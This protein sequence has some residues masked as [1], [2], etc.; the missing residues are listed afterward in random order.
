MV[1]WAGCVVGCG[2]LACARGVC[3][4]SAAA[5]LSLCFWLDL[6]LREGKNKRNTKKNTKKG[7]LRPPGACAPPPAPFGAALRPP[8]RGGLRAFRP[9]VGRRWCG[10][11]PLGGACRPPPPAACVRRPGL[12]PLLPG[13]AFCASPPYPPLLWVRRQLL[14]PR[15]LVFGLCALSCAVSCLAPCPLCVLRG[16]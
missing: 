8:L 15:C 12:P 16:V 11:L 2:V 7:G 3:A 14:C 6:G 1:L 5:V 9:A 10:V 13:G 4:A